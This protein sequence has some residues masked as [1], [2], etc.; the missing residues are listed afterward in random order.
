MKNIEKYIMVILIFIAVGAIGAAV[1]FGINADK[2]DSSNI[3]NKQEEVLEKEKNENTEEE[4]A[5]TKY[6]YSYK[7]VMGKYVNLDDSKSYII[8]NEDGTW[9]G[10]SNE[11]EG[12]GLYKG[13]YK[14]EKQQI[15]LLPDGNI[16][17]ILNDGI[18]IDEPVLLLEKPA[19]YS[20]GFAACSY[21]F[22]YAKQSN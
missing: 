2:D 13:T 7:D 15:E 6:Y 17:S 3:E 20:G 4:Q 22:Y 10:Q 11:C 12:Y 9:E 21:Q 5:G 18:S 1:Y 16:F 19:E 8:L 14:L